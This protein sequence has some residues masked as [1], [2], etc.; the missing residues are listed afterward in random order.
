LY[1]NSASFGISTS[2]S[3]PD[4]VPIPLSKIVN[5]AC[6]QVFC[7]PSIPTNKNYK[8]VFHTTFYDFTF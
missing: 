3:G 2:A 5:R 7:D 6:R 1:N 4:C 8:S